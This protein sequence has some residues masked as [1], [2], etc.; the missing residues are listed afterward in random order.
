MSLSGSVVLNFPCSVIIF[1]LRLRE[2]A[3][4]VDLIVDIVALRLVCGSVLSA[5]RATR[6]HTL[7]VGLGNTDQALRLNVHFPC[8][9][10]NYLNLVRSILTVASIVHH[11]HIPI[12]IFQLL[13][14][15]PAKL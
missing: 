6:A 9:V 11:L 15:S 3:F 1:D 13:R 5:N 7:A 4:E 14:R 8:T 2:R 12:P 10:L